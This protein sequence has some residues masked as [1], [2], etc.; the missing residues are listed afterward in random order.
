MVLS[1]IQV[2]LPSGPIKELST[3]TGIIP[4]YPLQLPISLE[5]ELARQ[6]QL[7]RAQGATTPAEIS[8]K[9]PSSPSTKPIDHEHEHEHGDSHEHEHGDSH[10]HEHGDS[11]DHEYE[12]EHD[13]GFHADMVIS[14]DED[15]LHGRSW[16]PRSLFL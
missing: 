14:K 5:R 11:H 10:E 3:L 6:F 2:R 4:L 9:R 8:P 13:H 16:K 7:L 1:L 15:W 12:E